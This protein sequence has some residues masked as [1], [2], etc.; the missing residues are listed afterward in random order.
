MPTT[1][2]LFQILHL[3]VFAQAKVLHLNGGILTEKRS[4]Q[5]SIT[6]MI[7]W[8]SYSVLFL[9]FGMEYSWMATFFGVIFT[10]ILSGMVILFFPPI[11]IICRFWP[12]LLIALLFLEFYK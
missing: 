5:M 11:Y 9:Y 12:L 1:F 6:V 2:Y 7:G 3:L 8:I 10:A 4:N